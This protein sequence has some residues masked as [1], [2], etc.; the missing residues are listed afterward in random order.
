MSDTLGER[1]GLLQQD[2]NLL[3]DEATG[4][5]DVIGMGNQFVGEIIPELRTIV[6][7]ENDLDGTTLF[8]D[9]AS[10]GDWDTNTWCGDNY[11]DGYTSKTW[12]R[13]LNYQN[14]FEDEFHTSTFVDSS[15]STG[16]LD[17]VTSYDYTLDD[18]E[19][20]QSRIIAANNTAYT[21]GTLIVN[22]TGISD[23]SFYLCA[24]GE[25]E[26]WESVS[27]GIEH[28]FTT[29]GTGGIK[30][31]IINTGSGGGGWPTSWGSWGSASIV[32]SVITSVK[33]KYS[34]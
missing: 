11:L 3:K 2:V 9:N 12:V 8:W 20:L 30:F 31:K 5:G 34:E 28:T 22:G 10:Q 7:S 19:I 32:Q 16:A 24:D 15:A 26:T 13:V 21:R 6:F 14:T 17:D 18:D 4:T 33:V 29:S 1:L 27:N 25:T 23:D